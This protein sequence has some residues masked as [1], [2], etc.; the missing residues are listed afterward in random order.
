MTGHRIAHDL[1]NGYYDLP[2]PGNGADISIV[3]WSHIAIVTGASGETNTLNSPTKAGQRVAFTM[4]TD[5]GGDR[6]ITADLPLNQTGNDVMTFGAVGDSCI[7]ESFQAATAGLYRWRVV[8]NDGVALST[9]G[10]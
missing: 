4:L 10:A 5:G 7:L 9:T 1:D 3:Q 8:Y 6:V 2:D